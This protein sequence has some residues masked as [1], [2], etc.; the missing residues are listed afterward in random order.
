MGSIGGP[1]DDQP[2]DR[3]HCLRAFLIFWRGLAS[4]RESL[5]LAFCIARLFQELRVADVMQSVD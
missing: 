3:F 4:R 1:G 5:L 2:S